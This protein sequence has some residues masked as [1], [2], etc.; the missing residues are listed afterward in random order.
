MYYLLCD[1]TKPY[2]QII[3]M[4]KKRLLVEGSPRNMTPT[5]NA[6]FTQG[7]TGPVPWAL[8][9][10]GPHLGNFRNLYSKF[11]FCA[12]IL[13]YNN[14]ITNTIMVP[15]S[16]PYRTIYQGADLVGECKIVGSA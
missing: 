12:N 11:F 1:V 14:Y 3:I 16:S 2:M 13:N 9:S 5:I 7:R 6:V 15:L 8:L 4:P 10:E